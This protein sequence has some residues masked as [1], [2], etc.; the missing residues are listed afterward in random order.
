M[1]LD[2][3]MAELHRILKVVVGQLVICKKNYQI[4]LILFVHLIHQ[5]KLKHVH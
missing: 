2:E 4:L 5:N 1:L 3:V